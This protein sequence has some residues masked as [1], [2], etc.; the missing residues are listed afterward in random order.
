MLLRQWITEEVIPDV[1][2]LRWLG[3][4]N[5]NSKALM[6]ATR[7]VSPS[8]SPTESPTASPTESSMASPTVSPSSTTT[9]PA[10]YPLEFPCIMPLK[11][12]KN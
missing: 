5:C 3:N 11:I 2:N 12:I 10:A 1:N 4:W 8:A 6:H 9:N 7:T